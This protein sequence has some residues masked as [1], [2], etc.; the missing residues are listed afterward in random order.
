MV[1]EM[2]FVRQKLQTS[3]RQNFEVL[4]EKFEIQAWVYVM[5]V[6]CYGILIIMQYSD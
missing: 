3:P 5:R 6:N 2:L 4:S 1:Y